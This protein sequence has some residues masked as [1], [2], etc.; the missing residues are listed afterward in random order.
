MY[1]AIYVLYLCILCNLCKAPLSRDPEKGAISNVYI[2][3]HIIYHI[4]PWKERNHKM[5]I[6]CMQILLPNLHHKFYFKGP[7]PAPTTYVCCGNNGHIQVILCMA[8]EQSTKTLFATSVNLLIHELIAVPGY[9]ADAMME[10]VYV[11]WCTDEKTT[12]KM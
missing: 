11:E 7:P 10:A 1:A 9:A 12:K 3:Y 8:R 2:S 6:G 5:V 4:H